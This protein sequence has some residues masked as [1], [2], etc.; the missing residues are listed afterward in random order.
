MTSPTW[1]ALP[2]E[3]HSTLLSTGAGSSPLLAAAGAWQVLGARYSEIAAELA[4]LLGAVQASA[5]QGPTAERFVAAH[6]PFLQWLIQAAAVANTAATAHET[7]AAGYTSALVAMPT[8]AELA[9]NHAVHGALVATNFFGINTIPIALN[10]SDYARMWLLAAATM[11]AYQAVSQQS[12]TATPRTSP[13]PHIVTAEG[14]PAAS[15]SFP[16]P[17]KLILQALQDF[18]DFLRNLA[19]EMLPGPLGNLIVHILDSFISLVSGSVFKFLAYAVLDPMIY[20][21]PFTPA[22][23]PLGLPAAAAG[24][25]GLAAIST[26]TPAPLPLMG[27]AHAH[28]PNAQISPATTGVTLAGATT[29]APIAGP[30]Q[31]APASATSPAHPPAGPAAAQGFYAIGGP[32]GDGRTPTAEGKAD[33]GAAADT[34]APA[35]KP[36]GDQALAGALKSR[37]AQRRVRQYRYE[38]PD[39]NEYLSMTDTPVD[40]QIATGERGA[41][42]SGFAGTIPKSVAGQAKGLTLRIGQTVAESTPEPMLPQTWSGPDPT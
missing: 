32:G 7:A 25:T 11:T 12:V 20:F 37:R 15:S 17:V 28:L 18:L 42:A 27:S 36:R 10:E 22:I 6:Q 24:L 13:A 8:L 38:F 21:G 3:I 14:S 29:G 39:A 26:A 16:D 35:A 30:A 41:D 4:G 34:V 2:P 31:P 9:T 23:S 40:K 33:A 19:A 5:W 1:F